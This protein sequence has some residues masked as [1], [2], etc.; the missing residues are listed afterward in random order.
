MPVEDCRGTLEFEAFG[1]SGRD[2][3]VGFEFAFTLEVVAVLALILVAWLPKPVLL[4]GKG[5]GLCDMAELSALSLLI[6][7]VG[8]AVLFESDVD[9][10]GGLCKD[11][12]K[13]E[14]ESLRS[15]DGC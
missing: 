1:T 12:G 5:A 6:L 13:E 11:D 7:L 4:C 2:N 10:M 14:D 15:V 9:S 8:A 3:V